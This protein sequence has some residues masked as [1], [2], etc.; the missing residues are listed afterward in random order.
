VVET[1]AAGFALDHN[2]K[3]WQSAAATRFEPC[4]GRVDLL[5]TGMVKYLELAAVL[6]GH[7]VREL[8]SPEQSACGFVH[9]DA[10]S[11]TRGYGGNGPGDRPGFFARPMHVASDAGGGQPVLRIAASGPPSDLARALEALRARFA[12]REFELHPG[13]APPAVTAGVV[14]VCGG[15]IVPASAC[16]SAPAG[17]A[18]GIYPAYMGK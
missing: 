7:A 18:A 2:H 12:G 8:A 6:Q 14:P 9:A 16:P 5:G 10:R 13:A 4:D 15:G 17:W 1:R 3:I 11:L